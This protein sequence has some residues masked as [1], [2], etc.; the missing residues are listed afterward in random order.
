M[1]PTAYA[2]LFSVCVV[3][4]A[5]VAAQ[6]PP[7]LQVIGRDEGSNQ[8]SLQCGV[9]AHAEVAG[10]IEPVPGALFYVND[11]NQNLITLLASRGIHFTASSADGTVEFALSP[12]LEAYY[13]CGPNHTYT[14]HHVQLLCK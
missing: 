7:V 3:L 2:A 9:P 10:G 1:T 8:I 14:S 13:F 6:F 4:P 11:T 5:L 12:D